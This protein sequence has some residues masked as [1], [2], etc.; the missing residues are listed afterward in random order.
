MSVCILSFQIR[1]SALQ[2]RKWRLRRD[3]SC[4]AAVRA[5]LV[6]ALSDSSNPPIPL[7]P[8]MGASETRIVISLGVGWGWSSGL[9]S[10]GN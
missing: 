1:L 8:E 3:M 5:G 4:P 2:I 7:E 10:P 6:K 9:G